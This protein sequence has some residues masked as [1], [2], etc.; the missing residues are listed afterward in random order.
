MA[1]KSRSWV[2]TSYK[3]ELEP[4]EYT[5]IYYGDEI[6][7]TTKRP[8]KQGW[9]YFENAVVK[10]TAQKRIGD[11]VCHI[12][13]MIG[14]VAQN[15]KYCSKDGKVFE[16]GKRPKQGARTD[17]KIIKDN[18]LHGTANIRDMLED[19]T[20]VNAQQL[21]FA[22]NLSK[23][24]RPVKR[25]KPFIKFIYGETGAGKTRSVEET[26]EDLFRVEPGFE[27]YDGYVGQE[28]VLFDDFRGQIALCTF[29]RITDRYPLNLKIKGGFTVW[30]PKRIYIT[31][32]KR[33]EDCYKNCGENIG[34]L[35]RRIDLI[36]ELKVPDTEVGR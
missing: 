34:Q 6:C 23:Y 16:D 8:H 7:P 33:P 30:K 13:M 11:P 21:K 20:I 24:A 10:K 36:E 15:V 2:F 19:D 26:E 9:V 4:S 35:L 22:E 12:E 14:T 18:I 27:W 31:S 3:L 29:L 28:A 32:C 1:Q 17:L 5:Y 25:D